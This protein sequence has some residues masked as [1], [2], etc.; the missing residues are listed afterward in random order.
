VARR[1]PDDLQA[2]LEAAAR[3]NAEPEV[4][5]AEPATSR[6]AEATEHDSS[7]LQWAAGWYPD[8][9][10]GSRYRYWNGTRWTT[11]LANSSPVTLGAMIDMTAGAPPSV[12]PPPKIVVRDGPGPGRWVLP[13]VTGLVVLSV[14]VAAVLLLGT[15]NTHAKSKSAAARSAAPPTPQAG[16]QANLLK[17]SDLPTG[18]TTDNSDQSS[19]GA[20]GPSDAAMASCLGVP[21]AQINTATDSTDSP[22]FAAPGGGMTAQESI[23]VFESAPA[24][25]ADLS[26]AANPK[27]PGCLT[28]LLA[29]M[30]RQDGGQNLPHGATIGAVTTKIAAI[31]GFGVP[32]TAIDM[33]MPVNV[34]QVSVPVHLTIWSFVVGRQ[35]ASV[36]E[37]WPG[38][39]L[40]APLGRS[41]LETLIQRLDNG[42]VAV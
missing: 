41:L 12:A 4:V 29:P 24:A 1:Q 10:G 13:V 15:K 31:G 17:L 20:D 3:D 7:P 19:G 34:G 23:G 22:T 32:M 11:D 16:A 42:A 38:N 2:W 14:I 26:I 8:P 37:T 25:N 35:E 6:Q 9:E 21:V 27:A 40:P 28:K 5:V 18:W 39:E 33:V 30:L 36:T